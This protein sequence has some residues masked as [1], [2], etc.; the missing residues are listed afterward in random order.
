MIHDFENLHGPLQSEIT[1]GKNQMMGGCPSANEGPDQLL[2]RPIPGASYGVLYTSRDNGKKSGR[3]LYRKLE[4][5]TGFDPGYIQFGSA[6]W[7]W[8]RQ[9]NSYVLQ[10]EPERFK[11]RDT[12]RLTYREALRVEK[13]RNAFFARFEK[14]L[15]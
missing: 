1:C 6:L 2:N 15:F 12:A 9:V 3:E 14:T 13:A 7:F 11:K 10:V 8:E 4:D 5:M